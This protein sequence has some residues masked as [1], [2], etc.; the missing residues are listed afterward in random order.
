MNFCVFVP[1]LTFVQTIDRRSTRDGLLLKQKSVILG[2]ETAFTPNLSF[3]NIY[4]LFYSSNWV[5]FTRV[6]MD[7]RWVAVGEETGGV[8]S[9]DRSRL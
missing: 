6:E 3:S 5:W 7:P 1:V 8:W 4:C 9:G 2:V